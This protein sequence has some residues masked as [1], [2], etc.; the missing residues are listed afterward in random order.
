MGYSPSSLHV[1]VTWIHFKHLQGTTCITFSL[2]VNPLKRYS[3]YFHTRKGGLHTMKYFLG[4][5]CPSSHCLAWSFSLFLTHPSHANSKQLRPCPHSCH[6]ILF[7]L[8]LDFSRENFQTPWQCFS[9]LAARWDHL[10]LCVCVCGFFNTNA[11]VPPRDS[12]WTWVGWSVAI[13][14]F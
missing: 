10:N 7:N 14:I 8:L 13:N 5:G 2:P 4:H 3:G 11:W 9:V 1:T 6:C 12:D